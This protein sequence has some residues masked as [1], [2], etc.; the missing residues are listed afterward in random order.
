MSFGTFLLYFLGAV[1]ILVV[2]WY[3][4]W[5]IVGV[6]AHATTSAVDGVR[7]GRDARASRKWERIESE[8]E[9][10]EEQP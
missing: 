1:V 4:F 3:V 10:E 5:A 7:K 6:T 2:G 8:I 9:D